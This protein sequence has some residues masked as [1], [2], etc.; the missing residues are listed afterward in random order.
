[1]AVT[2]AAVFGAVA[3][4]TLPII[5]DLINAFVQNKTNQTNIQLQREANTF[6]AAEA[7]KARDFEERM[8]NT[9]WQRSLQDLLQAGLNPA[10]AYT[11]GFASTPGAVAGQGGAA[12]IESPLVQGFKGLNSSMKMLSSSLQSANKTMKQLDSSLT[13]YNYK[14][15]KLY[16]RSFQSFSSRS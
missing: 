4:A 5:G 3:A 15:G 6:N 7:Q 1:M 12:K 9:A 2:P 14:G 13:T 10:L 11:Q 8:S 16:S